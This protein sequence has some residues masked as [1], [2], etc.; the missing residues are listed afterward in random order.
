MQ[1][2]RALQADLLLKRKDVHGLLPTGFRKKS[3]LLTF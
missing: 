3:D 1:N 2:M